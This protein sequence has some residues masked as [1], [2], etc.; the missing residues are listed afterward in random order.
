MSELFVVGISWR[1]APVAVREKLAFRDDELSATLQAMT[2]DLPVAEALLVSTCNRVEVYGVGKPGADPTG[3]V[4]AFLAAQRD[5]APGEVADVLYDHR[6]TAAVRHVFSVAS[7]LDSLVLGEAQILGQLKAAYG[8]ATTAGTSGPLLGRCLE[9]AF[10]VAKRVRTETAIARGAAN[11]STVSVDLAKRVFGNLTGKSVLVIGAGK[12]STLAARHLYASGAQHIVVTNR[13]PEKAEALAAEIDGIARPW[14]DLE[15]H[16]ALAD[17]V[18]SSTGA[19][20]PILTRP[21]FKRVTKA[22]RWRQLVVIDIAVPRDAD[23]AIGEFDGVYVFDI[24][25]LEK[26]VAANLAERARAAEHAGRIVEHEAGQFEHWMRTQGVVPTI[27]ALRERFARVAEAELQKTLD[28]LG[29]REH[30]QAQQRE[31]IQRLVQLVVNKL[32]HQPTI[33]LREATPDEAGLRAEILCQLFDLSPG[34]AAAAA[35]AA[36]VG[37]ER[38]DPAS[39]LGQL[40]EP[41]SSERKAVT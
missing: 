17:V 13:S 32:L 8:V 5:L 16:L 34:E 12:M 2:T 4:R 26:V 30:T 20:E 11:V 21:L 1:T 14:A 23:P 9:R 28:Q 40:A 24:D 31:A 6:G 27:R 7:A 38:A 25:D 10:G 15:A 41:A 33:A 18:I 37:A 22:R 3:P 36:P 29:R 35:P 19:R 39:A